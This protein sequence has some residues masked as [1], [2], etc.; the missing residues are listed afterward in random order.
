M[1]R[2]CT[3]LLRLRWV[4]RARRSRPNHAPGTIAA[5]T[6]LYAIHTLTLSDKQFLNGDAEAKATVTSGKLR[7]RR[8]RAAAGGGADARLGRHGH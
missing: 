8:A 5:R 1:I 4:S 2:I 6:E 7:S 3:P